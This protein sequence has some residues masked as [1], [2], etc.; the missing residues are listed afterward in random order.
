MNKWYLEKTGFSKMSSKFETSINWKEEN[1]NSIEICIRKA[2]NPVLSEL[3]NTLV[4]PK[5]AVLGPIHYNRG[6]TWAAFEL[7]SNFTFSAKDSFVSIA[8]P[9]DSFQTIKGVVNETTIYLVRT[10][11][12]R[13][14]SHEYLLIS[15]QIHL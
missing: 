6:S 10:I 11:F 8:L 4:N 13:L 12:F 1:L 5:K 9:F 14:F 3:K 15:I 2:L 7:Y